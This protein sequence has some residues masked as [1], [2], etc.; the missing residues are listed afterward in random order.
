MVEVVS[1]KLLNFG[2]VN[3]GLV[4]GISLVVSVIATFFPVYFAARKSPVEAIRSL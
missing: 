1:M 2:L 4:F 3:I